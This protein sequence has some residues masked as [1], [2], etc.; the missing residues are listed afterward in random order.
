MLVHE[1]AWCPISS[2]LDED[3]CPSYFSKILGIFHLMSVWFM[4]I[5][6]IF[7][8]YCKSQIQSTYSKNLVQKLLCKKKFIDLRILYMKGWI[9]IVNIAKIWREHKKIE[10]LWASK[11]K[12]CVVGKEFGGCLS[13]Y[14]LHMLYCEK[15]D[16]LLLEHV[17]CW[18][19]S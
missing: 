10:A 3:L 2:E 17:L 11:G 7:I 5:K 15:L 14:S 4:L 18:T 16:M 12:L 6:H 8:K 19:C 1:C 9:E 13:C